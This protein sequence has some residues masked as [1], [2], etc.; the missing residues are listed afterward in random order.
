MLSRI[1]P[2]LHIHP[3][4]VKIMKQNERNLI[5]IKHKQFTINMIDVF[6][7]SSCC[8][9]MVTMSIGITDLMKMKVVLRKEHYKVIDFGVSIHV[10]FL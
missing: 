8:V 7:A 3:F 5:D 1:F 9:A 2:S 6:A 4:L 10:K